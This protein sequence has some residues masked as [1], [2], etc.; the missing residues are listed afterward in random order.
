MR[1]RNNLSYDVTR[2]RERTERGYG[3][4]IWQVL[5]CVYAYT[6]AEWINEQMLK[7]FLPAR[8]NYGF[9]LIIA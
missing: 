7:M 2:A 5:R 9:A 4:N 1:R 8:S 3:Y 6:A